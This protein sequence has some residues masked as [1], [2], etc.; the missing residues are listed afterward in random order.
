MTN[1][2]CYWYYFVLSALLLILAWIFFLLGYADRTNP[3]GRDRSLLGWPANLY[4]WEYAIHSLLPY[5]IWTIFAFMFTYAS[6]F[7][8]C[9]INDGNNTIYKLFYTGAVV[10]NVLG[11]F[12]FYLQHNIIGA[13]IAFIFAMIF[14]F[15]LIYLFTPINTD[16]AWL[17]FPYFA[18]L[19]YFM[20]V[21]GYAFFSNRKDP[22]VTNRIFP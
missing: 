8:D 16:Y 7:I 5:I 10:L 15:V 19:L 9:K 12:L 4:M 22:T 13:L 3:D 21:L 14:V 11:F 20:Y 17:S 1:D 6:F 2:T 18:F